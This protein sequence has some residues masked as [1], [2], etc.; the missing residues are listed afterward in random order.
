MVAGIR[1]AGRQAPGIRAAGSGNG[2]RHMV[3][4]HHDRSSHQDGLCDPADCGDYGLWESPDRFDKSFSVVD[5]PKDHLA[6]RRMEEKP[7]LLALFYDIAH[8][9]VI[10]IWILKSII[11]NERN[12]E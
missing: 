2:I 4:S 8:S 9:T 3:G 5:L 1:L 11:I 7:G 10:P 12:R 6:S